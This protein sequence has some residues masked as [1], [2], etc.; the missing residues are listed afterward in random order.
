MEPVVRRPHHEH[1]DGADEL[2][3]YSDA[4]QHVDE[5]VLGHNQRPMKRANTKDLKRLKVILESQDG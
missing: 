2:G 3:G 4:E 5:Q 1:A